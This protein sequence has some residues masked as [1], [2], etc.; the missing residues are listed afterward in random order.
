MCTVK[1]KNVKLR[2][3]DFYNE[4]GFYGNL[5]VEHDG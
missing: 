1:K 3:I 5:L 2:I 4:I